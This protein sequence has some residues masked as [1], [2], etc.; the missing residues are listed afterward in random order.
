MQLKLSHLLTISVGFSKIHNQLTKIYHYL[1]NSTTTSIQVQLSW[2]YQLD[3]QKLKINSRKFAI[4]Y[5]IR[6][7]RDDRE[8]REHIHTERPT[9]RDPRPETN[10]EHHCLRKFE[11]RDDR[12]E[13]E[14][15][16]GERPTAR[17]PQPE[18]NV[19]HHYLRKFENGDQRETRQE[20]QWDFCESKWR[21]GVCRVRSIARVL[22]WLCVYHVSWLILY[23]AQNAPFGAYCGA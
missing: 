4:T 17:D 15:T 6:E 7:N 11:N 3:F 2:Q 22:W 1:Y 21:K 10:A 13:R 9:A 20:K 16:H 19:E 5:T 12:E 8:E 23:Y 14:Q 18:T